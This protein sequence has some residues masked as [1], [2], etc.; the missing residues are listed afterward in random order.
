MTPIDSLSSRAESLAV[1]ESLVS[2]MMGSNEISDLIENCESMS[3]QLNDWQLINLKIIKKSH[4][5]QRKIPPDLLMKQF[6]ASLKCESAWAALKPKGDWQTLLPYFEESVQLAKEVFSCTLPSGSKNLYDEAMSRFTEGVTS[7]DVSKLFSVLKKGLP[8]L[9]EKAISRDENS[10]YI[11]LSGAVPIPIQRQLVRETAEK[12]GFD[13][14]RGRLDESTHPFCIGLIGDVRLTTRYNEHNFINGLMSTLHETGHGLYEQNLPLNWSFQ[15]IGEAFC[16]ILHE[17]QSL[18]LEMQIA[19]T[20]PFLKF[21]SPILK[22]HLNPYFHNPTGLDSENMYRMVTQVSPS[23]IRTSADA[24]TYPLHII[25]RFEIEQKLLSGEISPKEIPEFWDSFM[26]TYLKISPNN[27]HTQGCMQ[28]IHWFAGF[29]GYFPTYTLGAMVAS[30]LFEKFNT[31]HPNFFLEIENGI[32]S[33]YFNWFKKNVWNQ[34][35]RFTM[36]ELV[37]GVTGKPLSPEP[38][39]SYLNN[40]YC[41]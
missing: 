32:F 2:E 27:N 31:D 18:C 24:L 33:S 23:L 5:L 10:N 6:E 29:W 9:I 35:S 13:F 36:S 41:Q 28:D 38:F 25:I 19:R 39:L 14:G 7:E 12:I 16:K 26:R 4:L 20:R 30:Q 34:G 11:A 21:L 8:D 3:H 1:L 22:K 15:P 17:S 40:R 37:N